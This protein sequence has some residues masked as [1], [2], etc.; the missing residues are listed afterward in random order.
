MKP[1]AIVTGG[2]GFI[3]SHL[4]DLLMEKGYEVH[5]IDNLSG[6]KKENIHPD[7]IL[8]EADVRNL[9]DIEPIFE[10]VE[11]VFHLAA[12]PQVQYSIEEPVKTGEINMGGTLN[13][14]LAA[15]SANVKKVIYSAS[16]AAYGDQETS[17]LHEGLLPK[18][19]S[20]YGLQKYIGEHYL[21]IWSEVYGLPTVSL[22]YFNVFG[23]RQSSTG[24]YASVI[25]KFLDQRKKGLPLA[26][27]GDGLQTRDFVHVKDVARA[28]FFAAINENMK[29]GEVINIGSGESYSVNDIAR[30]IGGETVHIEARLE[31]KNSLADITL[32]EKLLGWKPSITLSDGI[33][34]LL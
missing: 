12:L 32:S 25:A 10:G 3:G 1:R 34:E 5:I 17:P 33:K 11:F 26:I 13:V 18:P 9:A 15:R 20:P 31:P 28:N 6:G 22:R 24:A 29:G 4:T 30:I 23:P 16:S 8:H 2:A 14:L 27:T 7:A 19:K 21:R